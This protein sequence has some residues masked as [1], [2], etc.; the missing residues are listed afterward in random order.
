[1]N[2]SLFLSLLPVYLGII[3]FILLISILYFWLTLS[4]REEKIRQLEEAHKKMMRSFNELDE[5]AKLIVK[6][7]LELNKA[8]EELDK[9]LNGL[10]TLQRASRQINQAL[11][12]EDIFEKLKSAL[13]EEL[14]F[15]RTLIVVND[16]RQLPKIRTFVGFDDR[17][18]KQIVE[19][20]YKD[21]HLK[22]ALN[23][24]HSLSS[25]SAPRKTKEKMTHVFETEHYVLAPI[26]TQTGT[27]GFIFVGNRYDAPAVTQGDEELISILSGQIGQSLENTQL[28]DKVFRSS[29]EL[30][31]KVKERTK[32]LATALAQ[33]EEINRKK[34]EFISAVS[35]ELRT[36]LTSI[37]GYAAILMA[38]KIGEIPDAVKERLF[39]INTHSDNLVN[40]INNLLDIARIESGR[41]DLRFGIYKTKTIVDNIV[42]LLTPQIT[43][44]EI[45][46]KLDVPATVTEIC[47][48]IS[49]VER[50]FI[51]LLSNAI[52]FTPKGGTIA[53]SVLP[54]LE[55]GFATFQIAD[56]GIGIAPADLEKLFSEFFRVEN[57]INQTVKGTGLGLVLAKDI[58]QAHHGKIWVQSQLGSGTTFSF[59]LPTSKEIFDK[60]KKTSPLA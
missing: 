57:T 49:Q 30:E 53:L 10:N 52:K 21:E 59:T 6:T 17:K 40:L 39:K 56:T 5:Q 24:G 46:I 14:G 8:Q 26:I 4:S 60:S 37:K 27:L 1:M 35:H 20:L 23:E 34:T 45:K 16:E 19:S 22:N 15:S 50:V 31:I 42:D 41:I 12:E 2:N 44:K 3:I 9:R 32:Q 7:D 55:N 33:V 13:F 25:I 11:N 47:I 38:G 54:V 48:D 43:N 51:N 29:Q 18:V 58:I 28:F 36:P